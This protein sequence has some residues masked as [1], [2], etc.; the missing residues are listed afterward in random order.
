MAKI[1]SVLR[2]KDE[3]YVLDK[4]GKEAFKAKHPDV[5]AKVFNDKKK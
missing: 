4:K 2:Y 1:K 5:Y 3:R